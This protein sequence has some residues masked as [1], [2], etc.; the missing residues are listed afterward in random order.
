MREEGAIKRWMKVELDQTV[1]D[2]Y[3]PLAV[4]IV[5]S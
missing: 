1:Y 4:I 3:A 2:L 5:L